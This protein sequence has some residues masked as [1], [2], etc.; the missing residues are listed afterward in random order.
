GWDPAVVP[1]PQDPETFT[2]SKL[3]WDELGEGRHVRTLDAYRQ[4]AALRRELP[5][6]TDPA[7]ARN[8]CTVDE[9]A[10]LFTLRRG[11]VVVVVNFGTGATTTRVPAGLDLRFE[12]ESGVD[13]DG[14][15]LT[16]PGH[17]GALL[18]PTRTR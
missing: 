17:A 7:F 5:E 12:T 6:L 11:D 16:V 18:A 3:H 4:L 8:R 2:R 10:R 13:L 1:D 9:D 14:G 15:T